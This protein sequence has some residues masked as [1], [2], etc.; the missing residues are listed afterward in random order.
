MENSLSDLSLRG[1]RVLLVDDEP[2]VRRVLGRILTTRGA[3]VTHA[4]GG[5]EAITALAHATPGFDVVLTDIRM[6]GI[7][8][9]DVLRAVRERDLDA[10]VVLVTGAPEASSAIQALRLGA[11]DYVTKPVETQELRGIVNR[12]AKIARLSRLKREASRAMGRTGLEAGD[13]TSLELALNRALES[14][15]IAFQPIVKGDGS[16][17]GYEALMRTREASLPHPGAVLDAAERL[18]RLNEL[19][20]R[21]RAATACRLG[22]VDAETLIFVNLHASD[23]NDPAL[24]AETKPFSAFASRAVLEI[25]ERASLDEVKDPR[26]TAARLR[27]RGFKIAIDDLGAGYAGLT[28]FTSLE[29]DIAKLDMSLV[30]GVDSDKRKARIIGSMTSLCHD[31][32]VLIVAEG[33][34][35]REEMDTLVDLNCDLFQGYLI[36]KPAYPFPKSNWPASGQA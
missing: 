1:V 10:S 32:G 35:T 33:V 26:T 3:D 19:G 18:G 16:V 25:T 13:P 9:I 22:E 5:A 2:G 24:F 12:A 29:P 4:G 30:R 36:A 15:W 6:P 21:T 17:F 27:E 23:L 28:A 34:E 11:F 7:G 14:L 31:L 8:G 20:A